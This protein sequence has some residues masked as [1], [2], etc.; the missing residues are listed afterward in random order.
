MP[1]KYCASWASV[2]IPNVITHQAVRC[3]GYLFT[4]P[5]VDIGQSGVV[6]F[7]C[8]ARQVKS[9]TSY[10]TAKGDYFIPVEGHSATWRRST[11]PVFGLVYDPDDG[12]IRWADLT[13]HLRAKPDQNSGNIPVSSGHVLNLDSLRGEFAASLRKYADG[14]FG[15]ITLRLLSAPPLQTD[16]VYDAW[17]LGRHDAKYLLIIRRLILDLQFEALQIGRAHV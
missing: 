4:T 10:R 13:A 9:G 6:T 3:K 14:G 5:Y 8:A 17:A 16:A 2:S 11:I 12:L 15:G 7:L 1:A